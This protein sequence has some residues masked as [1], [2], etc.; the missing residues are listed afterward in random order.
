MTVCYVLVLDLRTYFNKCEEL[1]QIKSEELLGVRQRPNLTNAY[2]PG[3]NRPNR[4]Q[5]FQPGNGAG[6][7]ANALALGNGGDGFGGG[8]ARPSGE[9]CY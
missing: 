8:G 6:K 9:L 5:N 1:I 7:G 3:A 2:N 4:E